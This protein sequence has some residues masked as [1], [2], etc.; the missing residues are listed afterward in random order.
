MT[1]ADKIRSTFGR[2]PCRN[3]ADAEA[4]KEVLE[5]MRFRLGYGYCQSLDTV[6]KVIPEM[7]EATFDELC[8]EADMAE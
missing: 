6:R 5:F 1:I 8:Y 7:D 2:G 4:V 3:R